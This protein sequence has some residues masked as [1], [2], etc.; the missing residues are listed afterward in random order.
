MM[1]DENVFRNSY[2]AAI[3]S[4]DLKDSGGERERNV[5]SPLPSPGECSAFHV[6][7]VARH[8][9]TDGDKGH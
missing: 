5:Q 8:K 9:L 7:A 6:L 3:L 4:Y 2:W 1:V